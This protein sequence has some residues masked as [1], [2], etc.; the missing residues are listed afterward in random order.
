MLLASAVAAVAAEGCLSG[1]CHRELTETK[2][3]H[4]PVAAEMA[5]A[6]GC[7]MCHLPAGS[8]CTPG[9]GGQFTLKGKDICLTCHGKGTGTLHSQS[10]V[11]D[12]CLTCHV[13]HGSNS[14]PNMLREPQS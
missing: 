12:K 4:G 3:L 9:K 2:Y 1:S 7:K 8:S 5:G 6:Q 10:Q 11:E 13:P 14:S